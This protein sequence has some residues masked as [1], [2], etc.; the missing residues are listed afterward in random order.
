[1]DLK[2]IKEDI[3]TKNYANYSTKVILLVMLIGYF[4]QKGTPIKHGIAI[5][6]GMFCEI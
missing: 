3:L 6:A 5:A 2:V 1:M 4:M